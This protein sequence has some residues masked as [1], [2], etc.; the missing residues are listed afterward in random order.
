[1]N[2][3]LFP[4]RTHEDFGEPIT[5]LYNVAMLA[6]LS[7][8]GFSIDLSRSKFLSPVL[9]C[10]TA[11]LLRY[12]QERGIGS[13]VDPTCHDPV[14]R[15]Y[16]Q[17]IRF[18]EGIT[19]SIE[20][21]ENRT[22]LEACEDRSFIPLVTFPANLQPNIEREELIQGLENALV[23]KCFMDGRVV[24]VLKY[25]LSEI[26]GNIMYHAGQGS[27]FFVAQYHPNNRYLDLAIADTGRGFRGTYLATGK[28][29]P[30][31]DVEAMKLALD[32]RS[33]KEESHR[34]FGIRT[35][36]KMLVEGLGGWFM[37]WSGSAMLIDNAS[38]ARL[39]ELTDGTVLPGCFFA[40]RIPLTA[41]HTFNMTTFLE[42]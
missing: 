4:T 38:G 9:L 22:A 34:G 41:P 20:A 8:S 21:P 15:S 27:G 32:G 19:G 40:L 11:A 24:S 42:G 13:K 28:H 26:T 30:G 25:I 5:H 3:I 14:L 1:M 35:S 31:N 6:G 2:R 36:R 33:T 23:R 17:A 12:H 16:L 29:A 10:G 37:V 18:P 39:M 7:G